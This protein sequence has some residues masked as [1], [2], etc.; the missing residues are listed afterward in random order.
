MKQIVANCNAFPYHYHE[1]ENKDVKQKSWKYKYNKHC[2][3]KSWGNKKE[4][5]NKETKILNITKLKI[6]KNKR[7]CNNVSLKKEKNWRKKIK[8]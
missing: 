5:E 4:K 7:K 2:K 6:I 3:K 1:V 8:Y